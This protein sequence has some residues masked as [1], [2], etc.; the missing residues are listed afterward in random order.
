MKIL[1]VD[2]ND[3]FR[4]TIRITLEKASFQVD[5]ANSGTVALSLFSGVQPDLV[6]LDIMMPD[7]DGMEVCRQLR[8]TSKVPIIFLSARDED[9]DRIIGLELGGDDY[10]TK[11]FNPRELVARVKAVLRRTTITKESQEAKAK[12]LRHGRITLDLEQFK[13]FWEDHEIILT[14]T[15]FG[16][17]RTF[18][19]R[20][21]RVFTRNELMGS[22][23]DI[24]HIV[25]DR[26]IDSHIRRVRTKFDAVGADIIE[27]V[28]GFGYKLK[29]N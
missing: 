13:A 1:I 12:L 3:F 11:P 21:H 19:K 5:E 7:M 4:E 26:T 29:N 10:V 23:Y 14:V 28:H 22:A 20:P 8:R 17:L 24:Y 2:D 16:I 15:E 18:L 25:S 27:T 9:I 6:I